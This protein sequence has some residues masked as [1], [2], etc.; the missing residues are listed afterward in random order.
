MAVELT[1]KLVKAAEYRGPRHV[2]TCDG[3]PI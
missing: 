1:D 3:I 2:V